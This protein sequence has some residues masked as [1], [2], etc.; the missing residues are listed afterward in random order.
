MLCESVPQGHPCSAWSW[1]AFTHPF[2]HLGHDEIPLIV[3]PH[4]QAG[5]DTLCQPSGGGLGGL[6]GG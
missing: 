1:S 4:I 3:G 5:N 6:A 2:P